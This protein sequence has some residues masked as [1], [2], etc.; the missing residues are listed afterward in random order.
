MRECTLII[1]RKPHQGD[2]VIENLTSYAVNSIFADVDE[3]QTSYVRNDCI[4]HMIE[5][6]Y[7]GQYGYDMDKH[8][9]MFHFIL[10]T[11]TSKDMC[12][13]L[14]E[15]MYVLNEYFYKLGYQAV[16]VPHY[17]SA[18][19]NLNY[20]CH[21]IVNPISLTTHI[22]MLDKFDTYNTIIDYLNQHTHSHWC[23]KYHSSKA[24]SRL[25]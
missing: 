6:F 24:V 13:I 19:D 11:R 4:D 16:L 2:N 3:I 20:H 14:E 21:V 25:F 23:W 12:H 22:R 15:S 1:I 10:T 7:Q 8:R 17:G 18:K 9:R 5:D